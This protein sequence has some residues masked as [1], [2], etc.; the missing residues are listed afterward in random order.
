MPPGLTRGEAGGTSKADKENKATAAI[1]RQWKVAPT[2]AESGLCPGAPSR[3][4]GAPSACQA[5][6]RAGR[7]RHTSAFWPGLTRS[8][9]T[10]QC[11]SIAPTSWSRR[12]PSGR[13][14][15]RSSSSTT[16]ATVPAVS[17]NEK[18]IKLRDTRLNAALHRDG[19]RAVASM[20]SASRPAGTHGISAAGQPG[21]SQAPAALTPSPGAS[22]G[23]PTRGSSRRRHAPS[24]AARAPQRT[25]DPLAPEGRGLRAWLDS[26]R[27]IAGPAPCLPAAHRLVLRRRHLARAGRSGGLVGVFGGVLSCQRAACGHSR[28]KPAPRPSRSK[29]TRSGT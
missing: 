25:Q 8:S 26:K 4:P 20:K 10:P 15:L 24:G 12:T 22:P 5:S 27:A 29:P 6:G 17:L 3:Q 1:W 7:W 28:A 16:S 13:A 14:W 23:S 18:S 9:G 11:A 19:S 21:A 2:L